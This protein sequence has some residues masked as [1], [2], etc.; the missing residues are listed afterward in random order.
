MVLD[1]LRRGLKPSRSL[2]RRRRRAASLPRL[3]P[4]ESRLAPATWSGDIFDTSPGVP[5]LT[6]TAVQE[7]T[8]NVHVPAGQTLI[9]QAGTVVQFDAGTSLTVDGTLVAQG[10]A[11]QTIT[12]TSVRD[13]SPQGGSNNA[14]R[15]DWGQ[16]LFTSKSTN[17]VLDHVVVRYGGGGVDAEVEADNTSPTITNCD[18]SNSPGF[19]LRL[20]GS[21]ATVTGDN[22]HD[23]DTPENGSGVG[24]AIHM[25]VNSQ[26][27]FSNI[28]F[29]NNWVNAV[30]IDP[31]TLPA[32]TSNWNNPSVVY[33]VPRTVTVPVGATLDVAAGQVVK[34]D[35]SLVV[36]GTLQAQGTAANP[37]IFTSPNDDTTL[38]GQ[39]TPFGT[40]GK[41]QRG[42]W[43][44]IQFTSTSTGDVL[45][46]VTVRYGGGG[47]DAEV[48]A[49][50]TSPTITNCDISNSPG[51]GLRLTGSNAT[52]TG[53]NFHDNDI[54]ENGS[55]VG[56]AIHMDVNSQP[57][58]S[59]ISFTNNWVNA[60][61]IDPGTLP[62]GTSNWNN[63]SVVY[64]V[65]R[66]V[67]VP[68]GAALN[69]AAGQIVKLAR[70]IIVQGTLQAQ[71]TVASPVIFTSFNDDTVGGPTTPFGSPGNPQP[72]DW[73]SIEFTSTSTGS[74]L[75][76]IEA[77]YGTDAG[78]GTPG[79]I[80]VTGASLTVSNSVIANSGDVGA[81]AD[82]GS[83]LNL[84]S[85]VVVNNTHGAGVQGEASATL[86]VINCTIDGNLRG[87][88]LNSPNTTLT[89]DLVTNSL[90]DG[91]LQ[92]GTTN[93]TMGFC[94]VINPGANNY[95]GLSDQTNINHNLSVDPSYVNRAGGDYRIEPGSAVE[96]AGTSAGAPAIDFLGNPRFKDPFLTGRGDGSGY[97]MGAFEVQQSVA[98]DLQFSASAYSVVDTDGPV[99][100]TVTRGGNTFGSVTV[101]YATSDGTAHAGT[102]YLAAS[103]DLT[104]NTGVTTQTFTVPIIDR[105]P[106]GSPLSLN[107]TLSNPRGFDLVLGTPSS[108]VLTINGTRVV[109]TITYDQLTSLTG[110]NTPNGGANILSADGNRAVFAANSGAVYTIN[111][112]GSGL[113]LVDPNGS[114]ELDISTD[115]SVVLERIN[116]GNSGDEFFV[117]NADGSNRHLAFDT[118]SYSPSIGGRISAD[119]KT[120]Y[121]EDAAPF[122][123][124]NVTYP[125]GVYAVPA[126]GGG[127]PTQIASQSQVAALLDTATSNTGLYDGE[128]GGMYLG[129]GI[130]AD[131]SHL[132]FH[133]NLNSVGDFLVGVNSD[134]SGL[135]TIGPV[136]VSGDYMAEDG[137]SGDGSTV[138]RYD[139]VNEAPFQLTVYHFDGSGQLT[140]S[141][142]GGLGAHTAGPEHVELTQDGSKLLLG[143]SALLINT[144]GS[145]MTQIGTEVAGS[146]RLT[147]PQLAF[148]TM[149]G[150]GTEFLYTMSD[151]NDLPQLA[152]AHLNPASLGGDP[153]VSNIGISPSYIVITPNAASSVTTISGQVSTSQTVTNVADALLYNGVSSND[154]AIGNQTVDAFADNV[155]H[156]DGTHG[157]TAGSNV[158][159]NNGIGTEGTVLGPRTVRIAAQI[160]DGSG[161]LHATAVEV[162][163]L[164]M[165]SQSPAIPTSSVSSLPRY[166]ASTSLALSWSGTDSGGS[167]L[168]FY[169]VYVSDDGGA[170]QRFLTAT[171][172]TSTTFAGQDGHTYGFYS[173]ATDN[174]G[175]RQSPPA[176][177][178]A[179]TLVDVTPPTSS[180]AALP[181][182]TPTTS[183][184]VSWSGSDGANGSGIATY[185]V[186]YTDNG[187]AAQAFLTGTTQTS[188]TFAGQDG[189]KYAFYS[190][191]TDNAG[192]PQAV[193]GPV[194]T[195]TVILPASHLVV[196]APA[197]AVAGA[198]FVV[199][200]NAVN[201]DGVT[202]AL[203]NGSVALLL[204]GSPAGSRLAGDVVATVQK[205]VATFPGLSLNMV[206]T[207][208]TLLAA[209]SEI[210]VAGASAPMTVVA[211][212]H[213]TLSGVPGALTAGGSFT[214]SVTALTAAGQPNTSYLG[215]IHFTSSDP[216]AALPPDATFGSGAR[217]KLSFTVTLK[218]A[219]SQTISVADVNGGI[220]GG[221]SPA[222]VVS[223]AAAMAL[224][225]TGYPTTAIAGVAHAV[226]VTAVDA[227][228]NAATGYRGRVQ[229]TSDDRAALLPPAYTFGASDPGSHR[230]NATLMTAGTWSLKAADVSKPSLSASETNINVLSL[231]A[232]VAGPSQ[233]LANQ[234][235]TFTLSAAE[236]GAPT[237][238]IFTYK[239]D[240]D[241]NGTVDQVVSGASG[242]AVT[243]VFAAA[244]SDTIKVT[245][246]D[247]AGNLTPLTAA[248]TVNVQ[249][250][251]LVPDPADGSR[252]ALVI[253]GTAG[254]DVITISPANS[255]GT[256]V[257]LTINGTVQPGG[258]FAP[259]GDILVYGQG[260]N[261]T[262]QEVAKAIGGRTVLV[263]VPA[264]L[265]AGSGNTTLSAAGSSANN[266]LVGG[267]GKD[268]L[269]GGAG[270]DVLI[271]GTGPSSLRAGAGGDILIAGRTAY[272]TNA[273]AL[274]A[275]LAEWGR[276]DRV[277]ADRV[278][279]LFGAGSGGLNG[280]SVL[281][282][283]AITPAGG[284]DQLFGGMGLDWFWIAAN[285]VA[286]DQVNNP[287]AGDVVTFQ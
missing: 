229:L 161:L 59:N 34:L 183:F 95:T 151:L 139:S 91:V 75:N 221:T 198:A 192:N 265:V 12:F 185:S 64:F 29:T 270:R 261:D 65:P 271:G 4:L 228:G 86:S 213:F 249:A 126:A 6:N 147:T 284:T 214:F 282:P 94:N 190:L 177:A 106:L 118:D 184:A 254:N 137:I 180:V 191:A 235:L 144:D 134:G 168:A 253:E 146:P 178:Q 143:S 260:G 244:G 222:V 203:Y 82:T 234:P 205:G 210:L 71:G 67:A 102:D 232:G 83:S 87:I 268:S 121:F 1:W 93:L 174:E 160:Q 159:T 240:W 154:L 23:N 252:T 16:I 243:H 119:G 187:G 152:V 281:A 175:N 27:T 171:T 162:D 231:T 42:D 165:V 46:Y 186:F 274:L 47:V 245:A 43:N 81:E 136:G 127:T 90:S 77:L 202:D 55:G 216:K 2:A 19:G 215:T 141:V 120:V 10:A 115:G 272:D 17:D 31:G 63:P 140:L 209:S 169:D 259:T 69:V 286:A 53:D 223:A 247:G 239:I 167:G 8:G 35:R 97:D 38:G 44:Q 62:A 150:T 189:H 101:H 172:G 78:D 262:I 242:T 273:A 70:S 130:S 104:F 287:G 110:N 233:G 246:V 188:A 107:L 200:V 195:T 36:Q 153:A 131:G 7:F 54:P 33:F 217:G 11:G 230:F 79:M 61:W 99:T 164:T 219:G 145:G 236:T 266:V 24:G 248:L 51:F 129:L 197:Q 60:V 116:Q 206:G 148:P 22:F 173:V 13:N 257:T 241:G 100:I 66:T 40:P 26:P 112:D 89:S 182:Y 39:T 258:P 20:T 208:Y 32:G 194:Q 193:A 227:F 225:V 50:N 37:V 264:V 218:T 108:A 250:A 122:T 74:A 170:F 76:H 204:L 92:H 80:S 278:R 128:P 211:P 279:D 207:G 158:Y 125:S 224:Q 255:S 199:T 25:D 88:L 109:R 14:S 73:N 5:L 111:S 238:A 138:F 285:S 269:T 163:G 21:N 267:G 263:A 103:G 18:I 149:N 157:S 56:G 176:G 105:G 133:A 123:V 283:Q 155:L 251:A 72:G 113:T 49:D 15:G 117:V 237:G 196:H 220:V 85:C 30:W 57:T 256:T 98:S 276:T 3:E 68:R 142:P 166:T 28:T 84:I 280:A 212:T 226:T 179:T 181:T 9:I 114:T 45:N 124:N 52:V 135:H 41:P 96:D 201:A 58:F 156:N 277:Y 275:I 48:E 132:V